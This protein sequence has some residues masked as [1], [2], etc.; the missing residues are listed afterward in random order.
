MWHVTWWKPFGLKFDWCVAPH[1][2]VILTCWLGIIS[3]PCCVCLQCWRT[4]GLG[5]SAW[6]GLAIAW[7]AVVWVGGMEGEGQPHTC[8]PASTIWS[9]WLPPGHRRRTLCEPWQLAIALLLS[10]RLRCVF[11]WSCNFVSVFVIRAVVWFLGGALVECVLFFLLSF[12][13]VNRLG[14]FWF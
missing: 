12:F 8:T 10:I 11:L 6:R 7:E 14:E 1:F 5:T 13:S 2:H 9:S 4:K 3:T